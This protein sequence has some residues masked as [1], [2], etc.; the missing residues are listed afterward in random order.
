MNNR[1]KEW[2]VEQYNRNRPIEEQ[3]DSYKEIK[4]Q[5]KVTKAQRGKE[6]KG[7]IQKED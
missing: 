5:K 2:L 4:W 6:K 1:S 3:I 7:R